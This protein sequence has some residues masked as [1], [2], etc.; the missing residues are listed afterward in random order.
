MNSGTY[1]ERFAEK[2]FTLMSASL[3]NERW[4]KKEE[5]RCWLSF[6]KYMAKWVLLWD[7][8]SSSKG[9]NYSRVSTLNC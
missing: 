3:K 7:S 5:E 6:R 9:F 2:E 1:I 4:R 8:A